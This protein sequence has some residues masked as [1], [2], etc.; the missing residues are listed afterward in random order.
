M[1]EGG[2]FGRKKTMDMDAGEGRDEALTR[3]PTS[4]ST[5]NLWNYIINRS[6]HGGAPVPALPPCPPPA[7]KIDTDSKTDPI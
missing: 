7:L 2:I 6:F 4:S 3:T 1:E 5:Y